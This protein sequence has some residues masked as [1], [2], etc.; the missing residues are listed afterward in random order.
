MFAGAREFA[1]DSPLIQTA[2]ALFPTL[3]H[4]TATG[5]VRRTA[6]GGEAGRQEMTANLDKTK[7]AMGEEGPL[8]AVLPTKTGQEVAGWLEKAMSYLPGGGFAVRAKG[9]RI[10]EGMGKNLRD[11]APAADD[12]YGAGKQI[13]ESIFSDAGW[14]G[15]FDRKSD[16]NYRKAFSHWDDGQTLP[17]ENFMAAL[18]KLS[19]RFSTE[20]IANAFGDARYGKWAEALDPQSVP[21][22]VSWKDAKGDLGYAPP[23]DSLTNQPG[24]S[25]AVGKVPVVSGGRAIPKTDALMRPIPPAPEMAFA[26]AKAIRS[27][28]G[29]LA[30]KP[31]IVSG[32][33]KADIQSLYGALSDDV[34]SAAWN[35]GGT[36]YSDW[37]AAT[38]HWKGGISDIETYL[39]PIKDLPPEQVFE[40]I[41]ASKNGYDRIQNL[42]RVV[43]GKRFDD[44]VDTLTAKL[45]TPPPGKDLFG[46]PVEEKF[47]SET[48]LTNYNR[49]PPKIKGALF[50]YGERRKAL[51]ALAESASSLRRTSQNLANPAGTAGAGLA[52]LLM[53]QSIGAAVTLQ[54]GDLGSLGAT[55]AGSYAGAR[56]LLSPRFARWLATA[57]RI[58]PQSLPAHISR[59]RLA[60]QNAG[61]K[62]LERLADY[63]AEQN[64]PQ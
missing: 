16:S 52:G 24:P 8:S 10:Q 25:S 62:D 26:D 54:L 31:E 48:F 15:E 43:G 6:R 28:L 3:A 18:R 47:S 55:T 49:V 2:S 45:G 44:V 56:L 4:Q 11:A 32:F 58:P 59:L 7:A 39:N 33:D 9:E 29:K 22:S 61:D 46:N 50:G 12:S 60:A 38:D 36:A 14:V 17:A 57:N 64:K 1:P 30:G 41:I 19:G 63:L 53:K 40:S 13:Q 27:R 35:K 51:D 23:R 20:E 37:L 5:A 34:K 42:R 21:P